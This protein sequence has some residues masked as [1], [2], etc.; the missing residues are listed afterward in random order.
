MNK[1]GSRIRVLRESEG[2][3]LRQVAANLETDTV[4]ISKLEQGE[5]KVKKEQVLKRTL[6]LNA[7]TDELL[8]L[9]LSVQIYELIKDERNILQA[10]NVVKTEIIDKNI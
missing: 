9:W 10:L 3:L 6:M 1:F 7:N 8:I 2:L 4:H 5:R